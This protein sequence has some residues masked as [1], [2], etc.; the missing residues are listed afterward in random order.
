MIN[1]KKALAQYKENEITIKN[2]EVE[3]DIIKAEDGM[4]AVM[5]NDTSGKTNKISNPVAEII[6]NIERNLDI[7]NKQ[8]NILKLKQQKINNLLDILTR[9]EKEIINYRFISSLNVLTWQDIANRMCISYGTVKN[10]YNRAMRKMQRI[11]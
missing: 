7:I 6:C 1:V 4:K 2:L 3:R 5:L 9:E 8:I 10:T 11:A